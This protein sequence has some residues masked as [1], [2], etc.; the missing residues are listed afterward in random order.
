MEDDL[1]DDFGKEVMM[2][3]R[4]EVLRLFKIKDLNTN[5]TETLYAIHK[6]T[7]YHD[8]IRLSKIRD[9]LQ[10]APSTITAIITSLERKDLIERV[11]DKTDRRNICIKITKNG[12]E[13]I[14]EI[15]KN[16]KEVI[17]KYIDYMGKE[18]AIK[19]KELMSKTAKFL[20]KSKF[21]K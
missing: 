10:L 4:V 20:N 2:F 18:D 15:K 7:S 9:A 6:S 19:F 21:L 14:K 8:K 11:I 5:E 16:N 3:K 1:I 13:Y 17:S 12:E